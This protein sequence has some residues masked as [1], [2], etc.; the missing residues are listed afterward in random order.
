[1]AKV[2]TALQ[3]SG[4]LHIGNYFGAIEPAVAL[5]A[6]HDL[7][8]FIVDYHAI[9]VAQKPEELRKNILMATAVYLACGIDPEAIHW[10][11]SVNQTNEWSLL[12]VTREGTSATFGLGDHDR[13][14][15][16]HGGPVAADRRGR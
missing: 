16:G 12:L 9:T 7:T 2:L 14:G 13:C 11:E 6:Q 8:M 5:Q 3:P 10:I 1:M 4:I 15:D